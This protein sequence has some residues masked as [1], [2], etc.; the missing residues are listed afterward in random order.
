MR[1][2]SAEAMRTVRASLSRTT[3]STT[4]LPAGPLAH[5]RRQNE[6]RVETGSS[7]TRD[8]AV[9]RAQPAVDR[10][11]ALGHA[12]DDDRVVVRRPRRHK[13]RATRRGGRFGRP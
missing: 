6:A 12:G 5:T 1:V 2:R 11:P 3:W 13:A 8:D 10:R 9:A 4:S 7:R